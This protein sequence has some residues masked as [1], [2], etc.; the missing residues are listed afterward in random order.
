MYGYFILSTSIGIK[1][2]FYLYFTSEETGI[3][4][5]CPKKKYLQSMEGHIIFLPTDNTF[6]SESGLLIET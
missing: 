4:K 6:E 1:Y 3:R 2:H 5:A